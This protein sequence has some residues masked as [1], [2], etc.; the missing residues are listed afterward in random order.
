LYFNF[1][2]AFFAQNLCLRVLPYLTVCMFSL[3]CF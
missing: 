3:F 1:F 2:S